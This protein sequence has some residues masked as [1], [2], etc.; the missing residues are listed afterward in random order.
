M[1]SPFDLTGK[2]ALVTGAARGLGAAAAVALAEAGAAVVLS[3][4][5]ADALSK[6]SA[7]FAE[8]GWEHCTTTL[9]VTNAEQRRAAVETVRARYGRLD[10]LINNAGIMLRKPV[11]DTQPG[12]FMRVLDVNVVSMLALAGEVVG[13]M[14]EGGYGR[15]VNLSSIMGAIG[16]AGQATYVASKHAVVGLT[17]SLAAEFGPRGITVNAIAPGYFYTEMNRAI[18]ADVAFHESVIQRTPLHRWAEPAEIG[19][20]VV[21]LSAPASSFVT[22]QTLLI[23]GGMT[24]T[25][26]GPAAR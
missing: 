6:A 1:T 21:F 25:V 16:R 5:E 10:I 13:I 8:N 22:G 24:V 11:V 9:D 15:I 20:S 23:D 12:E 18:V 7:R 19:G 17:K 3:D 14:S 4:L 26:P 2:V